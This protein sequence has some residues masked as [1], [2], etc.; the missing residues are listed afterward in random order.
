MKQNKTHDAFKETFVSNS[1][2]GSPPHWL[3]QKGFVYLNCG[4]WRTSAVQFYWAMTLFYLFC[5]FWI[6][7]PV[8]LVAKWV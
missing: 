7:L 2:R 8:L 6:N 1:K 4:L 3:N 5:L